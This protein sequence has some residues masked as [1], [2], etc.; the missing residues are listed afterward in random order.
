MCKYSSAL[1]ESAKQIA[2]RFTNDIIAAIEAK[3]QAESFD[4]ADKQAKKSLE[5]MGIQQRQ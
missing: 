2:Q 1:V 5:R 4:D 3:R